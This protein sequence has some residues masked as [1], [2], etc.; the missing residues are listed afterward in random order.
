MSLSSLHPLLPWPRTLRRKALWAAF[1]VALLAVGNVVTI[2]VLLRRSDNLAATVNM[3]GK[4]RMLGQR[5]GLEALAARERP[6]GQWPAVEERYAAFE[7]TYAALRDGG[8]AHG[9]RVQPLD[10]Q[11]HPTLQALH[12][13]WQRYR[14]AIDALRQAS[15]ATGGAEVEQAVA[16]GNQLLERTETLLDQL[17]RFAEATH[18]R[19][20]YSSFALFAL[21]VLL[22]ALGYA[23]LARRVLRPIHIL[24]R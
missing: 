15:L 19:A 2:Q 13:S 5:I 9:M 14:Q 23:L 17:V 21:D 4:M 12:A 3:A 6:E 20:L 24:T 18:Q 7:A 10:A 16:A 22:L 1:L 11:L 8:S